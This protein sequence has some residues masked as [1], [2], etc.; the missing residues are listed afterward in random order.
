[1]GDL[2]NKDKGEFTIVD[3]DNDNQEMGVNSDGSINVVPTIP[4]VP[5][6]ATPVSASVF[7]SVSTTSGTDTDYTITS[8]KT[9]FLQQFTVAV[10]G[11]TG[12][13]A[14]ELWYDPNGTGVGMT[15][16]NVII[17][18]ANTISVPLSESYDG[19]G[20]K[21]IKIRRRGYTSSGREVFAK[22]TGYE[23]TT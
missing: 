9:L 2:S 11:E 4:V 7:N 1:M 14:I 19:D 6:D 3:P 20:T 5:S 21:A 15:L 16:I 18:D 8:G 17:T 13:S 12:G 22:W 10:E 23:E